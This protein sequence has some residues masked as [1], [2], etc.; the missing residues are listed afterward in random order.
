M[1]RYECEMEQDVLSAAAHPTWPHGADDELRAHVRSCEICSDAAE[2]ARSLAAVRDEDRLVE[3]PSSG[4]VWWRAQLRMRREATATA[5]RPM[6]AAQWV[7]FVCAATFS[8]VWITSSLT[9]LEVKT[10]LTEHEFAVAVMAG[11]LFGVPAVVYF[12]V[13][14]ER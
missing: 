14:K 6:I 5:E 2:I 10:L 8:V 7:A 11:L 3:I 13:G 1:K 9:G 12:G 4:L